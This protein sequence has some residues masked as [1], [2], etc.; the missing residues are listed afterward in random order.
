MKRFLNLFSKENDNEQ[1][2]IIDQYLM[3]GY[4]KIIEYNNNYLL[5]NDQYKK[6]T[7]GEK[8]YKFEDLLSVEILENNEVIAQAHSEN[9][10]FKTDHYQNLSNKNRQICLRLELR[11]LF[12]SLIDSE[13][14][15][16]LIN[17][18]MKKGS[19]QYKKAYDIAQ[20][21]FLNFKFILNQKN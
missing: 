10:I 21:Y 9:K 14:K 6:F 16:P 11:L 1:Q 5:I 13:L 4:Q 12:N 3:N 8:I 15:I 7:M 20:E 17:K 2:K 18:K 19:K